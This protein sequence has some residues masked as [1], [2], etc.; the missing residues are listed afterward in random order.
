M[1]YNVWP[2]TAVDFRRAAT[3][4]SPSLGVWSTFPSPLSLGQGGLPEMDTPERRLRLQGNHPPG[5]TEGT[6]P[7]L[8]SSGH[9]QGSVSGCSACCNPPLR[10]PS[11]RVRDARDRR[12]VL[13]RVAFAL[14]D[15]A[16]RGARLSRSLPP[17]PVPVPRCPDRTE[18][19]I[20]NWQGV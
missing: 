9:P 2:T 15:P 5:S 10:S 14:R 12:R 19:L 3:P 7:T 11:P 18:R 20:R 4:K 1:T 13:S 8:L 6:A 17:H 16:V